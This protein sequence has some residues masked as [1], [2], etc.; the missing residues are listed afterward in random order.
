[1]S[2]DGRLWTCGFETGDFSEVN[3]HYSCSIVSSPIHNGIYSLK[4]D[5]LNGSY[6]VIEKTFSSGIK[7]VYI[8]FYIYIEEYPTVD[9]DYENILYLGVVGTGNVIMCSLS[10]IGVLQLIDG[11]D[12]NIGDSSPALNKNTWYRIEIFGDLT[13]SSSTLFEVKLNGNTFASGTN[14]FSWAGG[15]WSQITL[16]GLDEDNLGGIYY[17][18]DIAINDGSATE[19]NNSW[20]GPEGEGTIQTKIPMTTNTKFW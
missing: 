15:D 12:G 3:N 4:T 1:M 6:S 8:R 10:Y 7:K 9:A 16:G 20:P 11:N 14:D 19:T 5:S 17:Y 13:T 18:D 2:V